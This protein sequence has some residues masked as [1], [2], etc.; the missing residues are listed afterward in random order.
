MYVCLSIN[1]FIFAP[2]KS[3]PTSMRCFWRLCLL[4]PYFKLGVKFSLH[5]FVKGIQHEGILRLW[6]N[7]MQ[8]SKYEMSFKQTSFYDDLWPSQHTTRIYLICTGKS[9][10]KRVHSFLHSWEYFYFIHQRPTKAPTIYVCYIYLNQNVNTKTNIF[11]MI[12]VPL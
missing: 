7:Y 4:A 3:L 10:A 8:H 12:P 11:F 2:G 1:V 6:S 5:L 9:C